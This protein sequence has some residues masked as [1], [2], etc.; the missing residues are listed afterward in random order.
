MKRSNYHGK[1]SSHFIYIQIA[2]FPA[3]GV[4]CM[5]YNAV[6]ISQ[7]VSVEILIS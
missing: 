7:V 1:R 5:F 4:K 6:Q 2:V 3:F